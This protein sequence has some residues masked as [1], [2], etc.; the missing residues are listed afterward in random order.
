MKLQVMKNGHDHPGVSL[1]GLGRQ[2][3]SRNPMRRV[4][5]PCRIVSCRPVVYRS[6]VYRASPRI[7]H[8]P[9]PRPP[10]RGIA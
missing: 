10:I 2:G 8:R 3:P 9:T 4:G 5:G 1:Q 6:T 7:P